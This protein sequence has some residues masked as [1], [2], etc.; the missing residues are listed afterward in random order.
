MKSFDLV[1]VVEDDAITSKITELR[2]RQ[3]AAFGQVQ[4]YPNGQ[5]ALEALLRAAAQRAK[6]PDLILLDLNMPVMDG[7]EF[8][9]ALAVQAWQELMRVCVLTSSIQPDDIAKAHAYAEVKGYFIKPLSAMLL[10]QLV[11]QLA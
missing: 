2:L 4:R 10:D 6:L 8:L 9:D 5:P 1:Y 3:H 11:Q 7:W